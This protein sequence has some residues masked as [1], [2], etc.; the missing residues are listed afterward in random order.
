MRESTPGLGVLLAC[1][2][3][4]G[5]ARVSADVGVGVVRTEEEGERVENTS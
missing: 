2:Q 3:W 4:V 1:P 5:Y